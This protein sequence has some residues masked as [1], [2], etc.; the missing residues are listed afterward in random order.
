MKLVKCPKCGKYIH[1]AVKCF[2]CGNTAGFEEISS[3]EVRENVAQEYARMDVLIEDKKYNEAITLSY[4]VLE[5][6]PNLAGVFWLRLLA[7]YKCS[8]AID[9]ICKGFPC[10]EDADFCNAL[11]F[12]TDEEHSAYEDIK[13]VVSQIRVLLKKEISDHE[14]SSKSATDIMR[15]KKTMQGE[16]ECRKEKLFSLWSDLENTEHS[17]YALEMDCRLLMKEHQMGLEKAAQ[18]A[19][20][21]K[22]E[23]YRM[24]ECTAEKLHSLQVRMGNVLQLSESSKD[25]IDSMK[26]QHPWVKSFF[27]LVTKRNEKVRLINSEI[28]SLSSY[29]RTVQQIVAEIEHIEIQH[30]TALIAADKYD[31]SDAV[32]L[33]GINA[34]NEVLRNA[35]VG[36]ASSFSVASEEKDLSTKVD[37]SGNADNKMVMSDLLFNALIWGLNE[38]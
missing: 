25:S 31:F 13:A 28:S 11:D 6:M 29:E 3:G 20:A 32:A 23:A 17:L 34:F 35:G 1:K 21:I 5:W 10:D 9:L 26:K 37:E 27:D 8:T 33:L 19:A 14:Y 18:E 24:E 2:H 7:K 30:K 22:S 38:N 4:T 12:S 36:I 16:I 15:I